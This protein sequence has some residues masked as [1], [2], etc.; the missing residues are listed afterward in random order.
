M[1]IKEY[2]KQWQQK[3]K[4]KIKIAKRQYYLKNKQYILLH[5]KQYKQKNKNYFKKYFKKYA[6]KNRDNI[7]EYKKQ[8]YLKNKEQI[9]HSKKQYVNKNKEK[10]KEY[11]KQYEKNRRKTDINYRILGCLR[12]RLRIAL[13]NNSKFTNTKKLIGCNVEH[14][15]KHLQSK[16]TKGMSWNNYGVYGWH[17]DHIKPCI[18]FDLS[19]T[20]QQQECFH[21]TNLQPLWAEDNLKKRDKIWQ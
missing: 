18:L 10:I 20:E 19:K 11:K 7:K 4:E 17:I 16:F 6:H 5:N 12:A 8:Y 14:L 9:R 13:K 21:Y 3:N 2:K 1:N 15:K